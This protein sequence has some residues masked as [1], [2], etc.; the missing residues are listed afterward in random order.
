MVGKRFIVV[1]LRE[2]KVNIVK[3]QGN[4]G[5]IRTKLSGKLNKRYWTIFD[6]LHGLSSR[7]VFARFTKVED[8]CKSNVCYRINELGG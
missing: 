1:E 5:E 3:N 7:G 8:Y 4:A 2:C 6:E